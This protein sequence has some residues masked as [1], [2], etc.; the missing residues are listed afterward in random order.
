LWGNSRSQTLV[1][2]WT[3]QL[4]HYIPLITLLLICFQI[5]NVD[6]LWRVWLVAGKVGLEVF[7]FKRVGKWLGGGIL[8]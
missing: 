1:D 8:F 5:D 3:K 2:G 6:F 4:V 7:G